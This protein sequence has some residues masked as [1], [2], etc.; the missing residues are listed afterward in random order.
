VIRKVNHMQLC[1]LSYSLAPMGILK[2]F[3]AVVCGHCTCMAGLGE[4]WEPSDD[5]HIEIKVLLRKSSIKQKN[6]FGWPLY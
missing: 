2:S 1:S 5:L 6:Y 4:V 3:E